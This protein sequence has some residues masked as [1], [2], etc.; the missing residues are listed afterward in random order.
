VPGA[1]FNTTVSSPVRGRSTGGAK[2]VRYLVRVF[3]EGRPL[4]E[5]DWHLLGAE[6]TTVGREPGDPGIVLDDPEA[7]RRHAEV[8]W[9]KE[10]DVHR[11]KDLGS[12][13]QSF[14]DGRKITSD[15]LQ[16]GSVLRIGGSILVYAET[17]PV[18]GV[19][20]LAPSGVESLA[21]LQAEAM[22]D[23]V[24]PSA[25]PVL[26]TGPTG[27]GKEVLSQRIHKKSRRSGP[28]IPVNCSTFTR[29]LIGSELFGHVS[30][31][32]S[33]ATSNR[34]GLFVA[35]DGGTL[36]LDEI[37]ELPL[38]QQPALLR[39]LQEGKV[40]PIGSDR[41]VSVEVRV[42]AATHQNLAALAEKGSFRQDLYARLAG[43]VI[44][45]PGL[46]E[47]R[48]EI[49]GLFSSFVADG[50]PP[51]TADAAEALLVYDW[52]QNIRELKHAAERINLF[53]KNLEVVDVGSLPGEIRRLVRE[54]TEKPQEEEEAPSKERLEALL[55]EHEGNVAQVARAVGKHRQQLYRW[56]QKHGLDPAK[57]RSDLAE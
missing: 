38:E 36:F 22:A 54:V 40:R 5:I 57:Y 8:E 29:E 1:K 11:V 15:Y 56:L 39:A 31:A 19:G 35:A 17:S 41:E 45:L 42:V 21:R 26:V 16:H 48:E 9:V 37:A 51:L 24:A 18:D 44:D 2:R 55:R 52:P 47:R 50:T 14:L 43:F 13:N 32:F 10:T 30:G 53:G 23:L 46:V 34:Q 7:S 3:T 20:P 49:L 4:G 25:L 12:R 28:L 27:A 6:K 33:G